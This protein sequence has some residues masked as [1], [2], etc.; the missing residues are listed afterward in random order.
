MHGGR[1]PGYARKAAVRAELEDWGLNAARVDPA[2]TLLRLLSQSAARV[3][4]YG[5]L[6]AAA[7]A[8]DEDFPDRFAGAGVAALIGHRYDLTRDGDPVAVAEAIRGLVELEAQERDRCAR[9]AKLAL[10]AGIEERRVRVAERQ[11]ET[12]ELVIR[13]ALERAGLGVAERARVIE[14]V[15]V[16]LGEIVAGGQA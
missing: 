4:R 2:E 3:A 13:A 12:L 6:L 15:P 8:G 16:V 10:D 14:A 9:F 5:G 11:A 1:V 7:Y